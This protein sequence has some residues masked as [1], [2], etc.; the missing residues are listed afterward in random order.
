MTV[1]MNEWLYYSLN[2]FIKKN[3]SALALIGTIFINGALLAGIKMYIS[4]Y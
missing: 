3:D 4:Q 2:Q 1:L